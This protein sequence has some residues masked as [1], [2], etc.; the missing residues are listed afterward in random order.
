MK[1]ISFLFLFFLTLVAELRQHVNP[2]IWV[3]P[4]MKKAF[5]ERSINGN[6]VVT[7]V[8]DCRF[9]N[10]ADGGRAKGGAVI[11]LNRKNARKDAHGRDPNH[12][13]E[14]ALDNYEH[15]DLVVDN[16][17]T[18]AEMIRKAIWWVTKTYMKDEES[19]TMFLNS[20]KDDE[21]VALARQDGIR[22]AVL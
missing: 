20:L 15:F 4:V 5:K 16:D 19:G 13:S 6:P 14:T 10:E 7:I 22:V 8:S 12:V 1:I 21:W 11:R 18:R 17:G 2:D 3:H 9:P